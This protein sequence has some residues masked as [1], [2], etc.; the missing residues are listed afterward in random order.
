M[1]NSLPLALAF[2]VGVL[3]GTAFFTGLRWTVD[4]CTKSRRPAALYLASFA[5]RSALVLSAFGTVF[6]GSVE[7]L[8]AC[9]VG[10]TLARAVVLRRAAPVAA[11]AK[12]VV[13]APDAR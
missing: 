13:D 2:A 12:E 6:G 3:A 8:A 9:L 5:L 1:S 11:T 4:A 10:F 7:R